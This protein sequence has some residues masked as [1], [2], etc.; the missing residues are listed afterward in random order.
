MGKV[1]KLTESDLKRI[2]KRVINEETINKEY[3]SNM[4]VD[5]METLMNTLPRVYPCKS[6]NLKTYFNR[7]FGKLMMNLYFFN[8]S[9]RNKVSDENI[10]AD[11]IEMGIRKYIIENHLDTIRH[12]YKL[13][14]NREAKF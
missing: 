14:C 7:L 5:I 9:F 3:L 1:V 13:K 2:V 6:V 10:N 4:G 8:D 11:E 12:Y